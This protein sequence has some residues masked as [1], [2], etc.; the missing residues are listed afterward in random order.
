MSEGQHTTGP[1]SHL[2]PRTRCW[3]RS[4]TSH[5]VANQAEIDKLQLAVA[6]GGHAP[7][8]VHRPRRRDRRRHRGRARDRR[9][10]CTA[11]RGV[12][13]RRPRPRARDVHRRRTHLPRRRGRD[14]L[15]APE[16]LGGGDHRAGCR[17]GR[18]E[19]RAGHQAPV[20]P[21]LPPTWTP[22]SPTRR[23][24][25]RS[26]RST[27]P[28][29]T[30]CGCSTRPR[31]RSAAA[32]PPTTGTST[33]TSTRCPSTA[34]STSTPTSTSPT[35]S[36]STTPSPPAPPAGRPRAARSPSTSAAPWPPAP[37]PAASSPSTSR[38]TQP[39][40]AAHRA[41]RELMIYLHL[42]DGVSGVAGVENTRSAIS[43]RAGQGLVRRHQHPR[44]DPPGDRPQRQPAHR[45]LPAHRGHARAGDPDQRDLRLPA[46]HPT[47][48][49]PPTSTT[50]RTTT[51]PTPTSRN[52]APLCRGHHRYKTHAGWT[53]VR[54]GPTTFTWTSPHGYTYDWDTPHTRHTR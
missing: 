26:R 54:T 29:T 51:A 12:L 45:R 34:P 18:P 15:P 48:T 53:V 28:S 23:T 38:P 5:Q 2:T 49:D 22:T 43:R 52:L 50:S 37:S 40:A 35:P 4:T 27:A 41:K 7:R 16:D 14:P 13:R 32:R 21:T 30:P 47:I 3:P 17:C 11:G 20:P 24:G 9:T 44:H 31:P 10:R 6:V 42:S 1:G 36:T 33:S 39:A 25:A 46:L 8:R 19:D